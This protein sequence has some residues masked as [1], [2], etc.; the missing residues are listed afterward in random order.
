MEPATKFYEI[1]KTKLAIHADGR[2]D[3]KAWQEC[4]PI[5]LTGRDG[6][7]PMQKTSARILWDNDF[8][9]VAFDC[10]DQNIW[11]T[12]TKRDQPLY[13]EEV[14][15]IFIDPDGDGNTYLELE[16]S[17]LGI[18]WD[19]FILNHGPG[20]IKGILAWNSETIRWGVH[21]N[22]TQNNPNDIDQSWSAEIAVPIKD[23]ATAPN[24]PPKPGDKWRLNLYRIDHP[25]SNTSEES[26]WSPVSGPSFHD[27]DKFGE[28]TFS[29]EMLPKE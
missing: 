11:S 14:V 7:T 12:F 15:E 1:K 2:L 27:P 13:N 16:V 8:I 3:E 23:L 10:E 17:P 22:G 5:Q 19:G 20:K 29:G 21:L 26:L 24:R 25:D 28:V 9:Y 18:F 6:K 4:E